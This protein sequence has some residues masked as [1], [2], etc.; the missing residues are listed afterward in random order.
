MP[1]RISDRVL[2]TPEKHHLVGLPA[3]CQNPSQ[4]TS[5]DDVKAAPCLSKGLKDR[6]IRVGLHRITDEVCPALQGLVIGGQYGQHRLLRV[7]VQ[8]A[9]MLGNQIGCAHIFNEQVL[10]TVGHEGRAGEGHLESVVEEAALDG[11]GR[12]R[13]PFWPHPLSSR[14]AAIAA[15]QKAR[16]WRWNRWGLAM[17]PKIRMIL[18]ITPF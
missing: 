8:R 4:F 10:A 1:R 2:P 18:F 6:Q 7:G 15:A 14:P 9:A 17:L 5:G 11:P 13:G 16:E 12:Y 3:R